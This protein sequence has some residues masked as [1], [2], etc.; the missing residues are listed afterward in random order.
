LV[1]LTFLLIYA[2]SVELLSIK[3]IEYCFELK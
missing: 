2:S 3:R 1:A